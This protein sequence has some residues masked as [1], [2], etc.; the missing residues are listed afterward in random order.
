MNQPI[1]FYQYVWHDAPFF[2]DNQLQPADFFDREQA[3]SLAEA[4]LRDNSRVPVLLIGER[5]SGKTSLLK[6][7][8]SRFNSDPLIVP[9]II[10]WTGAPISAS[11]FMKEIFRVIGDAI[12]QDVGPSPN[13]NVSDRAVFLRSLRTMLDQIPDKTII[14]C[15]DEVDSLI[16][17]SVPPVGIEV[18]GILNT[19]LADET[20]RIRL[21]LTTT[22]SPAELET[23]TA[24]TLTSNAIHIR[25]KPFSKT[26]LSKMLCTL[27]QNVHGDAD[28][29]RFFDLSG[30][31][32]YFAKRLLEDYRAHGARENWEE[33]VVRNSIKDSNIIQAITKIYNEHWNQTERT[34][35]LFLVQNGGRISSNEM[36]RL[37][38]Q[39]QKEALTQ[40]ALRLDDR[41]YLHF[42]KGEECRFRIELLQH[43]F[44]EWDRLEVESRKYLHQNE[45]EE[46]EEFDSWAG[47]NPDIIIVTRE[48][49]R[50][51]GFL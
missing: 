38:S 45:S 6:L 27:E 12:D 8:A 23:R 17:D 35:V 2:V 21:L 39:V 4:A 43:W 36:N 24:Y 46:R 49:S 50:Q 32:P 3:K 11:E 15:I 33:N 19:L 9:A 51:K 44:A 18:L 34:L 31:W 28:L 10:L 41:G 25:I 13:L 30:G 47:E 14:L 1:K 42:H 40:A 29:T 5:R 7:I 48:D 16:L 26:D 22:L 20:L 37:Q